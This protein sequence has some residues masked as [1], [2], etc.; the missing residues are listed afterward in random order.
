[1]YIVKGTCII[2]SLLFCSI[3]IGKLW[4]RRGTYLEATLLGFATMLAV[5]NLFCIPMHLLQVPFM[6]LFVIFSML[7]VAGVVVSL[8]LSIRE[9]KRF[10]I[11]RF[12]I[13]RNFFFLVG[14]A[15]MCYQIWRLAVLQPAI[16]GDDVTYLTM[17]ND[18]I[19]SDRIQGYETYTGVEVPPFSLKYMATSYYPFL[20]YW[21]KLF[22]F[23]PLL[24]YKT[25]YP[26]LTTLF[27]YGVFWLQGELFFRENMRKKSIYFLLVALIVEFE[28]ISY[29][30]LSRKLLQWP[31][32]GKSLLYTVMMPLLFYLAI[33][34]MEA[35]LKKKEVWILS[36]VLFANGALSLMGVGY[37]TIM[38]IILGTVMSVQ[39]KSATILGRTVLACLPT[40][41]VL[42][43]GVIG[44]QGVYEWLTNLI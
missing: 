6:A 43:F 9:K 29:Q 24:L 10:P 16:Y 15:I 22:D 27:A 30:F 18:I 37:S 34:F 5:F 44:S 2:L 23:H 32:Q 41:A 13:Q 39:R 20:A 8:V 33:T 36:V 7:I 21:S 31:W 42:V 1:M 40:G 28:N 3:E 12:R 26:I 17:V 19:Y 35:G 38:L 25:F 14:V 11:V 4:Y